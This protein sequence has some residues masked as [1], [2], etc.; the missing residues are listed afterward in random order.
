M[1][2]AEDTDAS[3]DQ[4]TGKME[5]YSQLAVGQEFYDVVPYVCL[6]CLQN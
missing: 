1:S 5:K 4:K 6:G 3:C 2:S